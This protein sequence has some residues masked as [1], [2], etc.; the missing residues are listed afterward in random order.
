[1]LQSSSTTNN[2]W[3]KNGIIIDGATSSTYNVTSA[4]V[5][6]VRVKVDNCAS[7]LSDAKTLVVTDINEQIEHGIKVYP[8]PTSGIVDLTLTQEESEV[9]LMDS[10]GKVLEKLFTHGTTRLD[11]GQFPG[12]KYLISIRTKK[13][14]II[15]T[16]IK[17]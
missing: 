7:V 15:K 12:G 2:E 3:F 1:M 5:Y 13:S 6:S 8:N 16:V 4:G 10:N 11:L 14:E 17:K 9:T